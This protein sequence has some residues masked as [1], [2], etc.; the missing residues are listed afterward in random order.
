MNKDAQQ[1]GERLL[2]YQLRLGEYFS[3]LPKA[4][5]NHKNLEKSAQ[6]FSKS[7]KNRWY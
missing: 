7:K 4:T 5:T 6:N 1:Y 3:G 2:E